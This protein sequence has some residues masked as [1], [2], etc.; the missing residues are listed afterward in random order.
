MGAKSELQRHDGLVAL[1][2]LMLEWAAAGETKMTSRICPHGLWEC[3]WNPAL[4]TEFE[5]RDLWHF[6]PLANGIEIVLGNFE[7]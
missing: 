1:M 6:S 3:S 7:C 4:R 5:A 2:A